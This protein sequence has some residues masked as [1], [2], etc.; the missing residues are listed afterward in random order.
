MTTK[1]IMTKGNII[2]YQKKV[3]NGK[4][5]KGK[6]QSPSL[7]MFAEGKIAFNAAGTFPENDGR[8]INI[9]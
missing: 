7:L 3:I 4:P 5:K 2:T 1:N 9:K 6:Y 8:T